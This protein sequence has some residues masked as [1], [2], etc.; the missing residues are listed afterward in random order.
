MEKYNVQ[1]EAWAPFGE[2]RN[3]MFSNETLAEIAK[4]H[5]KSIAQVILRWLTQRNVAT[6]PAMP[7]AIIII[8]KIIPIINFLFIFYLPFYQFFLSFKW[9]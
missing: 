1:I 8:T 3:N 6:Y 4:N 7:N 2:G 5:N 9:S